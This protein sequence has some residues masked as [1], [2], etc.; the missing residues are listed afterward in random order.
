[1]GPFTLTSALFL[2]LLLAACGQQ[3]ETSAPKETPK[4]ESIQPVQTPA[5]QVSAITGEKAAK[6]AA[7]ADG[8]MVYN[9]VCVACH[10]QGIAGAPK[11]GDKEA[12]KPH[13][14]KGM[15]TL[16]NHAINGFTGDRGVMPPKGGDPS[17]SDAEVV[18]A[19]RYMVGQS[20]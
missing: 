20:R 19:V 15:E 7:A 12:W 5:Q 18:A 14:A 4:A 10:G 17:L 9:K 13:I 11:I 16:V 2:T 1:M 3:Q 8:A 6:I